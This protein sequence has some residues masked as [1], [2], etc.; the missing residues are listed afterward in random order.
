MSRKKTRAREVQRIDAGPPRPNLISRPF[1][2][3][4]L[5]ALLAGGI[6]W[7]LFAR[8]RAANAPRDIILITIDT[9]RADALG[10]A[11]NKNVETPFLDRLASESIVFRNAHAHNVVTLPSHANILT[12]LLPYQHGIRD[13]SGFTLDASHKTAAAYLREAGY[14]TG[15]FVSAFPLDARYG[16]GAGFDVY[17]DKYREGSKPHDFVIAER[18]ANETLAAASA[19][20]S[21]NAGRKRF[22]WVH[23]YE[24]HAP[25]IPPPELR[26]RYA[27]APYLGEVAATDAALAAFLEP[28]LREKPDTV[29][30]VTSDHGEA[31]GD[32]G[33][34]T[35]G[36]F[37]YEA[38]LKVPLLVRDPRQKSRVVDDAVWHID[39]LPTI[40]E[41]AGVQAAAGDRQGGS[42]FDVR[43]PRD[44]YFEALTASITRGWAPLVGV[45][46]AGRHKYIDLPIPELYDLQRDPSET[47]NIVATERRVT[48]QLR[49]Q[50]AARAPSKQVES[51]SVSPDESRKLLSLGYI[52][53]A[54]AKKSY[55]KEDD[56]KMLVEIDSA[57]HRIIDFYQRGEIE[58]AI[59]LARSILEK[60]PDMAAAQEML[61]FLL[62][63]NQASGDAI[64]LLERAVARGDATDDMKIRLGLALSESGRARE[65]VEVLRPF[66]TRRDPHMLNAYGIALADTG[67]LRGA[68]AQFSRAL[69]IDSTNAEAYQNLGVAALRARDTARARGYLQR[70]L[71]LND[72]L[73][74]A[75][76]TMG[77]IEAQEGRADAALEYWRKAV[78]LDPK[79]YDALL[80]LGLVAGRTG[81][82]DIARRA[83]E[84]FVATAPADRYGQD[85][86]RAR[87]LLTQL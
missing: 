7:W 77:V 9:L 12:G 78:Q 13:N 5:L 40:L 87:S 8:H 34:L 17:D 56:P 67:D 65:A 50:L 15:A 36:L 49:A 55:G 76:N 20:F 58:Q 53:G 45:L 23:L 79:Q 26:A 38:T 63:E 27:N 64:E 19:W 82:R 57:L 84:Q 31:L 25:Y 62:Q 71:S 28:I 30:I 48:A 16:L 21:S 3:I 4:A 85:I 6:G 44:G 72:R 2:V 29:V 69:E 68:I 47:A 70:A 81:R 80:N 51:A 43:E 32:H 35:H 75:L 10:F 37:T 46:R 24:P 66:A 18:P 61:A 73:P 22:A 54:A 41:A 39:V 60:R 74:L 59:A 42:L 33:E 11:G 83:L 14:A 1:V 86:A 52:T